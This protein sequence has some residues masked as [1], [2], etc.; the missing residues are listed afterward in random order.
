MRAVNLLPRDQRSRRGSGARPGSGYVVVG[1]LAVLL[2][3][4]VGYV[5]TA[6]QVVERRAELQE[7]ER[8]AAA[9]E[10]RAAAFAPFTKFAKVKEVRERSVKELASSRFDWERLVLELARVVPP[11]ILLTSLDAE[12][13]PTAA[14]GA[15]ASGGS[16]PSPSPSPSGASASSGSS[17]S[18]SSA[19]GAQSP[20]GGATLALAGCAPT[21]SRVAILM[22]RLRRLT[23]ADDVRLSTSKKGE[24]GAGAGGSSGGATGGGS[25]CPSFRGRPTYAFQISVSFAPTKAGGERRSAP[26]ALGGGS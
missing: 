10:A 11:E 21:Q 5:L 6:N 18:G 9:A 23:Q 3:A 22:L 13:S 8:Q 14:A 7:V 12:G 20:P 19:G 4:S 1:A 16:S 15:G 24:E 17:G 25:T 2:L 26:S